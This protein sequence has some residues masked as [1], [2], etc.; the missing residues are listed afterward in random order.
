MRQAGD[1]RIALLLGSAFLTAGILSVLLLLAGGDPHRSSLRAGDKL[2]DEGKFD[3]AMR[4]YQMAL[5]SEDPDVL[6]RAYYNLGN[7]YLKLGKTRDAIA[8]YENALLI[9]P[10]DPDAK[11]NLELALMSSESSGMGEGE[12]EREGEDGEEL[13]PGGISPDRG[14]EILNAFADEVLAWEEMMR[15]SAVEG[16][17]E[18]D[19]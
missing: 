16:S 14:E 15:S 19:W 7:C 18:P 5:E 8:C 3:E 17:N 13:K 10:S 4:R 12:R 11:H 1:R 2:Y 9:N 6:A